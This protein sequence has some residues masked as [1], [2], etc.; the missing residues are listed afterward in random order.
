M[1]IAEQQ[2]LMQVR[3]DAES[4]YEYKYKY[5]A[6]T[7]KIMAHELLKSGQFTPD[8]VSCHTGLPL[9]H[10]HSEI[11]AMQERN[12]MKQKYFLNHELPGQ[13]VHFSILQR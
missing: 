11:A 13:L 8:E 7:A 6:H 1:H 5:A 10:V 12:A 2:K 4:K 3:G 9:S